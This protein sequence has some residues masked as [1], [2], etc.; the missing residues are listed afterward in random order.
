MTRK[1]DV[2]LNEVAG[3]FDQ[4]NLACPLGSIDVYSA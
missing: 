4:G 2:P 1:L 3:G